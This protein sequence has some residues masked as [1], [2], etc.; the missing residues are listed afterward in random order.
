MLRHEPCLPSCADGGAIPISYTWNGSRFIGTAVDD[1]GNKFTPLIG[2]SCS[3]FVSNDYE[4]YKKCDKGEGIRYLQQVLYDSGLL[5]STSNKP[6][7]G[8]FGPETEYSIKIYQY[9][10][11][12]TVDGFV[13]GQWYHDLIENYNSMNG[14]GD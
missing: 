1:F 5:Y 8:Y 7:D 14:I 11:H 3:T 10:N 12:L 2:S 9:Q 6:V 4:P 13:E